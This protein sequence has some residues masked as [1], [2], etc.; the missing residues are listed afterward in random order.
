MACLPPL[1]IALMITSDGHR[2]LKPCRSSG[3][4]TVHHIRDLAG[5]ASG[6]DDHMA[7]MAIIKRLGSSVLKTGKTQTLY[8][9]CPDKMT[10]PPIPSHHIYFCLHRAAARGAHEKPPLQLLHQVQLTA[11]QLQELRWQSG[12]LVSDFRRGGKC[13]WEGSLQA[14]HVS[15]TPAGN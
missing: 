9:V 14:F 13:H 15:T 10:F 3:G 5:Q 6:H 2:E 8:V 1:S 4:L 12:G 11:L 7:I